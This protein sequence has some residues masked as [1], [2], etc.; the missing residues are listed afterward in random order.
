MFQA[1]GPFAWFLSWLPVL[2]AVA[3]V[4]LGGMVAAFTWRF[5]CPHCS[6]HRL[7]LVFI[8]Y[9]AG[10]RTSYYGC[11]HCGQ[12]VRFVGARWSE[13]TVTEWRR[14]CEPLR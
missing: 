1:D 13:A 7:R 10:M 9:I 6:C 11:D 2:A 8:G 5:R 4:L 3:A 14:Y 12:R